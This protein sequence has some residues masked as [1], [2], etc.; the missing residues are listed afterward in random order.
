MGL[1]D[2][3]LNTQTKKRFFNAILFGI[4]GT[5]ISKAFLML[6]N[7]IAARILG[8]TKYGI[9]S[10]INNT[11]EITCKI[12][13]VIIVPKISNMLVI[14]I[15]ITNINKLETVCIKATVLYSS[16]PCRI[17]CNIEAI[18]VK[19]IVPAV[20]FIYNDIFVS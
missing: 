10:L 15:P 14:M 9:Y 16:N 11:A 3:I 6:F 4:G 1:F 8:E 2:K 18:E 19:N 17:L 5:I 20:I 12:N 13:R 7:V